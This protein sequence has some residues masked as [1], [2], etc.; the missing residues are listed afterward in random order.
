MKRLIALDQALLSWAYARPFKR[1]W[2]VKALIIIGDAPTWMIT[3]VMAAL[4]GQAFN[5]AAFEQLATILVIGF[6]I[7]QIT[8]GQLKIHVNRRRPYANPQLQQ[9]LNLKIINR[10]PAHGSKELESFPSGHVLWTTLCVGLI[11]F[12]LGITAALILGWLIPAMI[13][14]RPFLGVHYPSDAIAGLLLAIINLSLT[15][16]LAPHVFNVL[17]ELKN[18]HGYSMAYWIFMIIFLIV[19]FKSWLKRV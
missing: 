4:I 6:M 9:A 12:Q 16:A 1:T 15:L 2:F 7:S 19:G 11:S 14:L 18:Y 3:T 10:D 17:N 8:F 13:F 5:Q